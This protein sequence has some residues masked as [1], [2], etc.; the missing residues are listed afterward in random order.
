MERRELIQQRAE[1]V[2]DQAIAERQ[3]WALALGD[4]PTEARATAAWRRHAQTVAAYRDRYGIT[5]RTPLGPAADS[6]VQ[7]IDVARA[8]AALTRLR[9]LASTEGH[10]DP[11]RTARREGASRSL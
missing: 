2:L 11:S 9:D 6:D 3:E 1:A 7:T 4:T 8:K 5:T 10:N